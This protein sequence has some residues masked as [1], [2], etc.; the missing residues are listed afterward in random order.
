MWCRA[1]E[2]PTVE[3]DSR[4]LS[5]PC[6]CDGENDC[7]KENPSFFLSTAISLKRDYSRNQK[8][9]SNYKWIP[10]NTPMVE[11]TQNLASEPTEI[12]LVGLGEN[13]ASNE[14]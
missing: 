14:L 2:V 9:I 3:E 13:L 6:R 7:E 5:G 8:T 1:V 12:R 11:P 10:T 4:V